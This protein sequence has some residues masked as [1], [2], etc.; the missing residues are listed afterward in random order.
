MT[1]LIVREYLRVSK[2]ERQTGKSPD[3]QHDENMIAFEREGFE[4]HQSPPYRDVDRSAS[5]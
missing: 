4:L 1:S 2:D 3:Q 5:R